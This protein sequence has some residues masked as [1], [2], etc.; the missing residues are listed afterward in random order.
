M[1]ASH[2]PHGDLGYEEVEDPEMQLGFLPPVIRFKGLRTEAA[3][4][5]L[6]AETPY[7]AAIALTVIMATRSPSEGLGIEL[8]F[9]IG[10]RAEW[11]SKHEVIPASGFLPG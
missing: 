6:A 8:C 11:W 7:P 4:A 2:L 9:T 10:V 3:I 1:N 5:N